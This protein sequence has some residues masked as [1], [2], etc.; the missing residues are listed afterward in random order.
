MVTVDN[1]TTTYN[2]LSTDEKPIN[3]RNGDAYIEIDTGKL[4][5]YDAENAE[6]KELIVS[7]GSGGGGDEP[8]TVTVFDGEI[9]FIRPTG[10]VQT[11]YY[12]A[13]FS[14]DVETT[15]DPLTIE[16]G[17]AVYTTTSQEGGWWDY[18][19]DDHYRISIDGS[20][21]PY[22]MEIYYDTMPTQDNPQTISVKITQEQEQGGGGT[23]SGFLVSIMYDWETDK[24]YLDKSWNEIK[25]A[26][27]NG[28]TP[29]V[30]YDTV[31]SVGEIIALNEGFDGEANTATIDMEG[32]LLGFFENE[33]GVLEQIDEIQLSRTLEVG[34]YEDDQNPGSYITTSPLND[35]ITAAYSGWEVIAKVN[36]SQADISGVLR[37]TTFR[38]GFASFVLNTVMVEN[39]TPIGIVYMFNMSL[40]SDSNPVNR[41]YTYTYS[42]TAVNP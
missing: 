2:G 19:V 41:I 40:D 25:E 4:F 39:N 11:D 9:E 13:S 20:Q 10:A 34:I 36:M 27:E 7:G 12:Q 26:L 37:L 23:A 31:G 35:V 28:I 1:G 29:V 32:Y 21:S 15:S 17:D 5:M 42:V 22:Y 8:V 30:L 38:D 16:I 14:P 6:W 33:N 24:L 3:G 18:I